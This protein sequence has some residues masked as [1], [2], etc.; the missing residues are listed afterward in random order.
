MRDM[1]FEMEREKKQ[2]ELLGSL[3]TTEQPTLPNESG[4]PDPVREKDM[5]LS[6]EEANWVVD[7]CKENASGRLLLRV[8][9]NKKEHDGFLR[10]QDIVK[11][12]CD[13][14]NEEICNVKVSED[15][16][17]NMKKDKDNI[18]KV[19]KLFLQNRQKLLDVMSEF[20]SM[21]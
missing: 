5:G 4:T 20:S 7:S 10:L 17:N 21:P 9:N 12:S 18:F 8:H 1:G 6:A 15:K 16:N 3:Q 13:F 19:V 11:F 14:E 2:E